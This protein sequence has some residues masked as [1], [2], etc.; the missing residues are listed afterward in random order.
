MRNLYVLGRTSAGAEPWV[1]T[2][3]ARTRAEAERAIS[4][5]RGGGSAPDLDGSQWAIC[6]RTGPATFRTES[7]ETWTAGRG[8]S[9]V[10]AWSAFLET[11]T[12]R[13]S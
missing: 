3:D 7:G 6:T 1:L 4:W 8:P 5:Q 13:Q 9:T 11:W 10:A 12:E 2:L